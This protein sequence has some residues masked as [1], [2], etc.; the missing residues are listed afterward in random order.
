MY[1]TFLFHAK[2][3]Q[4]DILNI[5]YSIDLGLL[6]DQPNHLIEVKCHSD[7]KTKENSQKQHWMKSRKL[8]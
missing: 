2:W 7:N 3:L 5:S 4:V 8:L 1:V 6:V